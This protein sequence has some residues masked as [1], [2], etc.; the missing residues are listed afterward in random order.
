MF[1]HQGGGEIT[2][3]NGIAMVVKLSDIMIIM[4]LTTYME[5]RTSY[6]DNQGTIR[7][8]TNKIWL[9]SS[10]FFYPMVPHVN[11]LLVNN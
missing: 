2:L 7:G 4:I 11:T 6:I 8:T 5:V 3:L 1:C 10:I 9:I